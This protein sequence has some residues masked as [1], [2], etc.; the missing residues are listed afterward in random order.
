MVYIIKDLRK[1][2]INQR[3]IDDVGERMAN[4]KSHYDEIIEKS[5]KQKQEIEE[6][7]RESGLH[8]VKNFEIKRPEEFAGIE[9]TMNML[10]DHKE[11]SRNVSDMIKKVNPLTAID[12]KGEIHKV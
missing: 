2:Q 5:R 3:F 12:E 6:R 4:L 10:K 11:I 1:K 7:L 8:G 9:A